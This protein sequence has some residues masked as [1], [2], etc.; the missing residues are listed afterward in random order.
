MTLGTI[1]R[2][3]E[4]L[5]DFRLFNILDKLQENDNQQN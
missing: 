5:F 3:V 1:N 2:K 4:Q